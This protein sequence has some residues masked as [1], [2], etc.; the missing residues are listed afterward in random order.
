M[1]SALEKK[2]R[3]KLH[4]SSN[5][6]VPTAGGLHICRYYFSFAQRS[7]SNLILLQYCRS[8]NMGFSGVIQLSSQERAVGHCSCTHLHIR[9]GGWQPAHPCTSLHIP[10][11]S[12]T[13][14]RQCPACKHV[15]VSAGFSLLGPSP[16]LMVPTSTLR[17]ALTTL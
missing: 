15:E 11:H 17:V 6:A 13:W 5:I 1:V 16:P 14:A 12:N 2:T 9:T 4:K 8:Y 10:A 7:L 3:A